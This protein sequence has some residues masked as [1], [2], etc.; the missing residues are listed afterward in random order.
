MRILQVIRHKGNNKCKW[1]LF[2]HLWPFITLYG[3]TRD[4]LFTWNKTVLLRFIILILYSWWMCKSW[5]MCI[6]GG[7]INPCVFQQELTSDAKYYIPISVRAHFPHLHIQWNLHF[8]PW[9]SNI[10]YIPRVSLL[11]EKN[12]N[13]AT[14]MGFRNNISYIDA[15]FKLKQLAEKATEYVQNLV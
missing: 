1:Q 7:C 5:W 6:P 3:W 13:L 11:N 10:I 9:A 14:Q 4:V 8:S 12:N 2:T 15:I